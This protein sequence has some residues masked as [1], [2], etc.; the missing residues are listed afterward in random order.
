MQSEHNLRSGRLTGQEVAYK[1]NRW[2]RV[3]RT[4]RPRVAMSNE[5]SAVEQAVVRALRDNLERLQRNSD[6]LHHAV[7]D[8]IAACSSSKPTNALPPLLRAQTSAASLTAA[9]EVLSRLIAITL[10]PGTRAPYGGGVYR[11]AST[12]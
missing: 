1:M 2:E 12:V 4:N 3:R 11:L 8:V 10:Q 6:E 7:A 5:P 9:L